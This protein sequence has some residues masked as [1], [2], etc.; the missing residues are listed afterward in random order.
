M[1]SIEPYRQKVTAELEKI[2]SEVRRLQAMAAEASTDGH[3]RF[4]NFVNE[5]DDRRRKVADRL[6]ELDDASREALADINEGLKDARQRLMIA[7]KAAKA[8]FH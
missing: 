5:I 1:T 3:D 2:G 6:D 7:K 4:A 8:R